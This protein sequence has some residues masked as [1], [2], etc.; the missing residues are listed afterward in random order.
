MSTELILAS[1][2]RARRQMLEAAGLA[3]RVVPAD[4]DE[5]A[6]RRAMVEHDVNG[7]PPRVAQVLAR[8][9]AEEVSRRF[10]HALVVGADQK[11]ASRPVKVGPGPDRQWLV[12]EGLSGGEQVVVEGFQK[13]R[14]NATVKAVPWK[15]SAAATA[16]PAAAPASAA[17][18]A[19]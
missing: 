5:E 11:V 8:V 3:F 7:G 6:H 4:V 13:L 17:S 9:K 12:L 15:P 16:A 2:S 19:R 1:G 14:P 18:A 10:P